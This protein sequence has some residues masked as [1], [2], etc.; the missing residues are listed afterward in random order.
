MRNGTATGLDLYAQRLSGAGGELWDAGGVVV[1]AAPDKQQSFDAVSL[2]AGGVI[3]SW[4]DFRDP[5]FTDIYAQRLDSSGVA[6]GL[7]DGAAVSTAFS[8]QF[9][10]SIVSDGAGGA[11]VAWYD[12][13]DNATSGSDVYAQNAFADGGI[14]ADGFESGDT[15]A[16]S[17]VVP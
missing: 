4:N 14:F 13:R 6:A 17:G 1:S 15:S 11:I 9:A 12:Y 10:S 5:T 8:S 3:T 2:G 7:V 16:W